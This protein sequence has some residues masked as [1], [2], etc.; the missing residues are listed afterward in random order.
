MR[1]ITKTPDA[2]VP[3]LAAAAD[4]HACSICG[5]RLGTRAEI[6]AG[7][8]GDILSKIRS[9]ISDRVDTARAAG[10][11]AKTIDAVVRESWELWGRFLLP[12]MEKWDAELQGA[13]F[14]CVKASR[15]RRKGAS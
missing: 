8:I 10:A 2:G 4:R 12:E 6:E 14:H 13:H 3:P 9:T 11:D 1:D 5:E 7:A 15:G